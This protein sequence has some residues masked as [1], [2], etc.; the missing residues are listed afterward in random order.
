MNSRHEVRE[1]STLE[2]R[3]TLLGSKENK[4]MQIIWRESAAGTSHFCNQQHN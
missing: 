1:Q 2:E 4:E 3:Q